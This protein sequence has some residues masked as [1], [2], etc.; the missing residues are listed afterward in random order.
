MNAE[1]RIHVEQEDS[2]L[3]LPVQALAESRGHYFSLVKSGEEYETR[4][5]E[6]HSTNDKVATIEKGLAEGEEVVLNPRTTGFLKLPELGANSPFAIDDA[7]RRDSAK[8]TA[9]PVSAV[10]VQEPRPVTTDGSPANGEPTT[11]VKSDVRAPR[12]RTDHD[13][14]WSGVWRRGSM[15]EHARRRY[16][17]C[18]HTSTSRIPEPRMSQLPT[19]PLLAALP[20]RVGNRRISAGSTVDAASRRRRTR[21][22]LHHAPMH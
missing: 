19:K 8:A 20:M 10:A 6:I 1:V 22:A 12:D 21:S 18:R 15:C 14:S 5:V 17:A 11:P 16:A 13:R 3:Q 2:A 4:E 7:K 9:T